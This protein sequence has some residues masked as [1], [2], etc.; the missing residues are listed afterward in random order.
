MET[1]RLLRIP[2]LLLILSAGW[3][4]SHPATVQAEVIPAG[5]VVSVESTRPLVF[6]LRSGTDLITVRTS[7]STRFS[8]GR[9]ADIRP[10]AAVRV[11]G[12]RIDGQRSDDSVSAAELEVLQ[13]TIGRI[14]AIQEVFPVR[15]VLDVAGESET[16][17]LK[18]TTLVT[19]RGRKIDVARLRND[20][21]IVAYGSQTTRR[22]K[23]AVI[24]L[25]TERDGEITSI[26]EVFPPRL[27]VT[28]KSGT[29]EVRLDEGTQIVRGRTQEKI[30]SLRTG[31]RIRVIGTES[32][33]RI[34]A[35]RIELR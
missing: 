15:L 8:A 33:G 16:V 21:W 29:V 25:L 23:V 34:S 2:A 19:D 14:S 9:E 17:E 4:A 35:F 6:Q 32:N 18:S 28:A 24:E 26:R 3:N 31:S 13:A 10:G 30:S 22:L 27:V 5:R 20:V 11:E 7:S 1:S 12:Q